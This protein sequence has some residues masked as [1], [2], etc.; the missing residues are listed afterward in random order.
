MTV[1]DTPSG[2]ETSSAVVVVG[3]GGDDC[4]ADDDTSCDEIGGDV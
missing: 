2:T 3:G 4:D 1:N